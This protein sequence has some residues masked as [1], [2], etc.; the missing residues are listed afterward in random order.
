MDVS[1]LAV[2][3]DLEEEGKEEE[4]RMEDGEADGDRNQRHEIPSIG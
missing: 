3:D 4:D 2:G 1:Q